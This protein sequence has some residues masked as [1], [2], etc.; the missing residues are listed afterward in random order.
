MSVYQLPGPHDLFQ[1]FFN[2]K[3]DKLARKKRAESDVTGSDSS[4]AAT[5]YSYTNSGDSDIMAGAT[6]DGA[7]TLANGLN[8]N[9][10]KLPTSSANDVVEYNWDNKLRSAQKGSAWIWVK[11][12]PMGN[13]V[14]RQ[15]YDGQNTTTKK[16]VVDISGKLPTIIA[17]YSDPNSLANQYIYADAQILCQ[18]VGRDDPNVTD[19]TYYYVHDRLG[20]VRLV[21]DCNMVT[22]TVTARNIYTYSP[23]GNP[24]AGTVTETVYNPFQFTGQWFDAEITQYYLRARQYDPTMMRFMTRDPVAGRF[25]EPLTLHRYLYCMGDPLNQTDPRGEAALNIANGLLAAA[26]VY[27]TGTMIAA[28]GAENQNFALIVLGGY[29]QQLSG[30]ALA[31]GT[32]GI[33][34]A[35]G[36]PVL[37]PFGEIP[38]ED[39]ENGCLVWAYDETTG[40]TAVYEVTRTFERR[41]DTLVLIT[42]DNETIKVTPEH[43]FYVYNGGWCE[44]GKL[45]VGAK[46][47]DIYGNPLNIDGVDIAPGP[48]AVYNFEVNGAHTYYVSEAKI[49]VHNRCWRRPQLRP[50]HSRQTLMSGSN[51]YSWEYWNSKSNAQI[52]ASFVDEPVLYKPDGTVMDGNTRLTILEAIS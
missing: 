25:Q 42:V 22:E 50:L 26:E 35:E 12:D 30:V 23:F 29:I 40:N 6:G 47:V 32:G 1:S 18:Y 7:F 45:E 3:W 52:I 4:S 46:L 51:R 27:A 10:T 38:I 5:D 15:S 11:Y 9:T 19:Q 39:I 13:R 41:A 37:T 17:E 49:L 43:P 31:I 14:W 20:S 28:V 36:T 21:V 33:C 24:Y 8:G 16:H 48:R 2:D 44:A 34:F